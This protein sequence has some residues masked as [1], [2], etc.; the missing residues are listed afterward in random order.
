MK[1]K[2]ETSKHESSLVKCLS[3][4][5]KEASNKKDCRAEKEYFVLAATM[6]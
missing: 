1:R 2:E 3:I 5:D 4:A 6:R